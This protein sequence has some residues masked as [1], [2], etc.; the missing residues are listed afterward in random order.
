MKLIFLNNLY[1]IIVYLKIKFKKFND[2]KKMSV[3]SNIKQNNLL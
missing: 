3:I 1:I 2:F